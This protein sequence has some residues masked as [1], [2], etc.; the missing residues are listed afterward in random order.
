MF[1]LR[2]EVLR[3]LPTDTFSIAPSVLI[4]RLLCFLLCC[5]GSCVSFARALALGS[6]VRRSLF[7]SPISLSRTATDTVGHFL[8]S[9]SVRVRMGSRLGGPQK[10]SFAATD[11][12]R[13][14]HF[15]D[16]KRSSSFSSVQ[17]LRRFFCVVFLS[18]FNRDGQSVLLLGTIRT[19]MCSLLLFLSVESFHCFLA[20]NAYRRLSSP[21][22]LRMTALLLFICIGWVLLALY[23]SSLLSLFS[24]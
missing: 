5:F 17:S 8:S 19:L 9:F 20:S 13:V 15:M 10:H 1:S 6:L 2:R 7:S 4:I 14:F 21:S 3:W 24:S 23:C 18:F 16:F 12:A 22:T 11:F